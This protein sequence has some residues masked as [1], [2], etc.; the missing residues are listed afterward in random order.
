MRRRFARLEEDLANLASDPRN[1][2]LNELE[3]ALGA[4]HHVSAE[5]LAALGEGEVLPLASGRHLLVELS[6]LLPPEAAEL[7]IRRVREAGWVPVLAHV[8]RYPALR[9]DARRLASLVDLGC[10]L[11][12]NAGSLL[13]GGWWLRRSCRKLL[14]QGLLHVVASDGHD[15][16]RR[17]PDLGGVFAALSKTFPREKI[18]AWMVENPGAVFYRGRDA[19][20]STSSS[21]LG[22]TAEKE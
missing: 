18:T 10:L 17:K 4:E 22:P 15:T 19:T 7:V 12:V 1:G 16:R 8:E 6:E 2:F 21:S 3:L 13:E 14:A 11:Q 20:S 9:G 5:F